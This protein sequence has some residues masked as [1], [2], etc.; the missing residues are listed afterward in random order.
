MTQQ[1]TNTAVTAT[2]DLMMF[3][4]SLSGVGPS[5]YWALRRQL[6]SLDSL[7]SLPL[8]YIESLLPA[9][10]RQGFR[11]FYHRGEHCPHWQ[12]IQQQLAVLDQQNIRVITHEDLRYPDCLH[13]IHAAPPLLYLKGNMEALH[14]PQLAIV[15]SRHAS[16]SG[17]DNAYAFAQYLG[18]VG[19]TITSGLAL[20]IDAQAHKGALTAKAPTIAVMGTG[21][22]VMY[23]KRNT[24]LAKT[25]VDNGGALVT[26]FP[27]GT[28]PQAQN[29]PR[30]NR[31]ISGLSLG[32]LVVE[33]ALAS[34]SLISAR[35]ALE[36][37]RE[38][39]AIPGSIHNPH[40]R[41][42]HALIRDGA[43]LVE[44]AD[45]IAQQLAPKRSSAAFGGGPKDEGQ[46]PDTCS[47]V[48]QQLW[49]HL[50]FEATGVDQLMARTGL[51]VD[52]V[53]SSLM[54]LQLQG[55]V[56]QLQN[57]TYQRSGI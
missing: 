14:S 41:G 18:S 32:V 42:C 39:F 24:T 22:D 28:P 33:A 48:E 57:Q 25:I 29:F 3:L 19:F 36:Q 44:T 50:G 26:E 47:E 15:G 45:D 53:V 37:N 7:L 1:S 17:S 43:T 40:A 8:E 54:N 35:Y 23:P 20:G 27:L 56:V 16:P 5:H 4:L 2:P 30:R 11:D 51:S 52:Q 10:A 31:I 38:V 9:K 55:W 12:S 13:E 6:S 46:L 49:Q 34:G 21:I